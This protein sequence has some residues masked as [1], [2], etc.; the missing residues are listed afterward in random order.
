M[1]NSPSILPILSKE[2]GNIFFRSS[3]LCMLVWCC[4][5]GTVGAW[6]CKGCIVVLLSFK[7]QTIVLGYF[8]G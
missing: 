7:G 2:S 3:I 1:E 4:F 8:N 5:K 6:Y